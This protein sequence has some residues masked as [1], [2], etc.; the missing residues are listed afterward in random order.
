MGLWAQG[1]WSKESGQ[2]QEMVL[3]LGWTNPCFNT[4]CGVKELKALWRKT[5]EGLGC[6][7]EWKAGHKTI[8]RTHSPENQS[9][10]WLHQNQHD[11]Q[12]KGGDSPP[13]L[14]SRVSP[15]EVLYLSLRLPVQERHRHVR[16]HP[17]EGL[18]NG[19][20]N[21]IIPLQGEAERA[22]VAWPGKGSVG[23]Y[24]VLLILHEDV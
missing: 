13:L 4:V 22:G 6:P 7:G 3:F 11:Q 17:E 5:G 10:P 16:M 2:A 19:W 9:Y 1:C 21:G 18:Q 20:K 12:A 24:S 15:A 14:H 8:K 23:P